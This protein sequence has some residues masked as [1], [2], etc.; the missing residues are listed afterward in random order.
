MELSEIAGWFLSS[1]LGGGIVG[2]IGYLALKDKLIRD[3]K[4]IFAKRSD[5]NALGSRVNAAVDMISST[6]DRADGNADNIIRLQQADELRWKP[7]AQVLE[8]IENR[9][10]KHEQ[11]I[12][13]TV[14]LLDSL[15]KRVD[16]HSKGGR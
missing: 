13:R 11:V 3:L 4:P 10:D 12:T 5:L 9:L 6:R 7:F 14:A 8:R 16:R 1:L 2:T 15:E